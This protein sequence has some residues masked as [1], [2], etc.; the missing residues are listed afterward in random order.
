MGEGRDLSQSPALIVVLDVIQDGKHEILLFLLRVTAADLI[1]KS[2]QVHQKQAHGGLVDRIHHGV[3]ANDG[4]D[5]VF[6]KVFDRD[7]PF[8]LDIEIIIYGGISGQGGD[9]KVPDKVL[10]LDHGDGP[11]EELGQNNEIHCDVAFSGGKDLMVDILVE[12][13]EI[14]LLEGQLFRA[15]DNVCGFPAHI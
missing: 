6:Q 5:H 14:A 4:P 13:E 12:K 11:V 7:D 8:G 15:V 3:T 1:G 2:G 9:Q 10:P